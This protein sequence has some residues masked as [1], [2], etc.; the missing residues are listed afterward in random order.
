M[1]IRSFCSVKMHS[2]EGRTKPASCCRQLGTE[3]I[4]AQGL[5]APLSGFVGGHTGK[6]VG[7]WGGRSQPCTQPPQH[8]VAKVPS[9]DRLLRCIQFASGFDNTCRKREFVSRKEK[10]AQGLSVPPQII[11]LFTNR[12]LDT[13]VVF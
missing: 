10:L 3:R 1:E 5:A 13:V 7:R 4:N 2:K 8:P 12:N 11:P 6:G 9:S